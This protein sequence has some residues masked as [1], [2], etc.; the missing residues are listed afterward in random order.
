MQINV[1]TDFLRFR[2]QLNNLQRQQL[3]FAAANALTLVARE[4]AAAQT[5]A[6]DTEIDNPTPFTKRA[7][8]VI[9]ARK[10]TLTATVFARDIQAKYLERLEL[11][12]LR[13]PA[14][15]ALVLPKRITL[16]RFGNMP[17]GAVKAALA[18]PRTFSGV[19]K[20]VA[21]IW[22]RPIRRAGNAQKR[23]NDKLQLLVRYEPT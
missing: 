19:V 2:D 3:P 5:A 14:K 17:K 12:G 23:A 9:P 18:R 11:G 6:L 21:G 22:Q 8:G 16:N 20:G 13:T 1:R 7:F 15:V 4:V 10:N